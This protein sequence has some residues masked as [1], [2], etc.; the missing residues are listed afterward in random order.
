MTAAAI[1]PDPIP[2]VMDDPGRLMIAR[3]RVPIDAL[4]A[5]FKRGESPEA[6]QVTRA[7]VE[8]RASYLPLR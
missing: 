3:T 7:N 8:G 4:A 1:Q 5:A 6:I 2:L